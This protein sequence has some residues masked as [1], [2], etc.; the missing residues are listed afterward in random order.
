MIL[1]HSRALSTYTESPV[2]RAQISQW[3]KEALYHTRLNFATFLG[4]ALIQKEIK[5]L[6]G[7]R[8]LDKKLSCF[9][10]FKVKANR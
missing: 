10:L 1:I 4:S 8:Q 6:S 3:A 5:G 9:N 2:S 7:K